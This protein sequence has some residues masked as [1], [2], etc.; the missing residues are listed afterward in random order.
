LSVRNKA[1]GTKAFERQESGPE[2]SDEE[3]DGIFTSSRLTPLAI[4]SKRAIYSSFGSVTMTMEALAA[5]T[6]SPKSSSQLAHSV[7][8]HQPEDIVWSL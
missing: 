3:K 4:V 2:L 8:T 6:F 1:S 5:T 7:G